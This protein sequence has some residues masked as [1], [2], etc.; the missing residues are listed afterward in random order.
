VVVPLAGMID[1]GAER[2]RLSTQLAEAEEEVRRV[3]AKLGNE[4]FRSKAPSDVVA[5]EEERLAA[6]NSR[7]DGLRGRLSELD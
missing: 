5:R 6:A 1:L 3:Q 2:K 4:Q 7:I